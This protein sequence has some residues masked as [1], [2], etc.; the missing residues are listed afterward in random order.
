MIDE[1]NILLKKKKATI[2]QAK[3]DQAQ[4]QHR[5]RL[6]ILRLERNPEPQNLKEE[7][8]LKTRKQNS[9]FL[10]CCKIS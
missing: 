6:Y 4:S 1:E 5:I 9:T 10:L 3:Q 8:I 7:A 2:E